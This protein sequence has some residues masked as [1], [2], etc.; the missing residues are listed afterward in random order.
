M[1]ERRAIKSGISVVALIAL[2]FFPAGLAADGQPARGMFLLAAEDMND[3][4]FREAVILI[5]EHDPNGSVGL[6]VNKPL[7]VTLDHALPLLPKDVAGEQP[8]YFGGPVNPNLV[9]VL[10]S[11]ETAPDY[12]IEIMPGVF[13]ANAEP[14]FADA[15]L[16]RSAAEIRILTGYAGWGPGQLEQEIRRGGWRVDPASKADVFDK[17]PASLWHYLTGQGGVV[18]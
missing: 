18:I 9:W 3:P 10:F 1:V 11:A 13:A 5:L 16:R 6:I 4:R 17:E 12:A 7:S 2:I 8:L 15:E 14:F